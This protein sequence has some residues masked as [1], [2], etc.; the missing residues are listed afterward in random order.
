MYGLIDELHDL[1]KERDEA[2][3][4]LAEIC[5]DAIKSISDDYSATDWIPKLNKWWNTH[6]PKPKTEREQ[7]LDK[8]SNTINEWRIDGNED[9]TDTDNKRLAEQILTLLGL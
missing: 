2:E 8:V 3:K 5:T 4:L 9:D 1:K 7:K 6:K